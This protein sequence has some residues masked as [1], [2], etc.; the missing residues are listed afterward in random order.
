MWNIVTSSFIEIY[1]FGGGGGSLA[2]IFVVG[3]EREREIRKMYWDK[4][5]VAAL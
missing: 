2:S 5:T 1:L 4:E 3:E